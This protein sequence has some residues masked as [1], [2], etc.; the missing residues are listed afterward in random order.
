LDRLRGSISRPKL[1]PE[2]SRSAAVATDRV[3]LGT[4]IVVMPLRHPVI[5]AKEFATLD[6]LSDGRVIFG[7]GVGWSEKELEACQIDRR[8]RGRRMDE[9]LE[10]MIGLWTHESFSFTGQYYSFEDVSL[11]PRPV[12]RPRPPIWLAGGTVPRGSATTSPSIRA[13]SRR[14]RFGAPP[15]SRMA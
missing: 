10:V 2:R 1:S 3:K 7:G 9:M 4:G 8:S 6:A 5:L 12:Q 14:A 15:L 13:T 11:Q